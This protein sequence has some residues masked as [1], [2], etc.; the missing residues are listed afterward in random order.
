MAAD[1]LRPRQVQ[2]PDAVDVS[3]GPA[4]APFFAAKG[5]R[6]ELVLA[7]M[8]DRYSPHEL[9]R[10]IKLL[11]QRQD[12][13]L[14]DILARPVIHYLL[15]RPGGQSFRRE[16]KSRDAMFYSDGSAPEG[17]ALLLCFGGMS[18][19]IGMPM[20]VIL[21][22]LDAT[23]FDVA[24]LRDPTRSRFRNGAGDFS[25]TFAETVAAI[26]T[27]FQPHRYQR[28]ISIGN[29]MGANPAVQY[30]V[31]AGA[32]RAV[33]VGA[34]I[35]SDPLRLLRRFEV[36]CAFDPLCDCLKHRPVNG[37]WVY[38]SQ[39]VQDVEGA[40]ALYGILGC[41]GLMVPGYDGH[42]VIGHFWEEGALDRLLP[43][44]LDSDLP[45][46]RNDEPQ[47]LLFSPTDDVPI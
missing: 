3:Q 47:V 33:A 39:N 7:A 40:E 46:Q 42:N 31:L 30:A 22:S 18:G 29:S 45:R 35:P 6:A 16:A 10:F 14:D 13:M 23:R 11:R 20:H 21:Q 34:R 1:R 43:L 9:R 19:R 24:L 15:T 17:K 25:A 32:E 27:V 4:F 36:P 5:R 38:G 2:V 44:L 37:L 12:P 8:I 28:V 41:Q 26:A